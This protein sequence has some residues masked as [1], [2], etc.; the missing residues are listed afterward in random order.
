[1]PLF[2]FPPMPLLSMDLPSS[3]EAFPKAAL[4]LPKCEQ[5]ILLHWG[6]DLKVYI[7]Y[8]ILMNTFKTTN[9]T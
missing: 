6:E 9:Y 5:A 8:I 3:T 2:I 4:Q 7:K 1:M